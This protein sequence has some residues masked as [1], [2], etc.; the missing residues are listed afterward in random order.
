MRTAKTGAGLKIGRAAT[1]TQP[2]VD[3]ALLG[4]LTTCVGQYNVHDVNDLL[5]VTLD[6]RIL[7][8]LV[9]GSETF[10]VLK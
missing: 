6:S 8:A 3:D 2:P 9:F 4:T 10:R 7:A 5:P 1:R